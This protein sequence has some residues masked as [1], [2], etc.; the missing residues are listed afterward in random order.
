MQCPVCHNE[1]GPQDAFCNHC[2]ASVTAAP[3]TA[4]VPPQTPFSPP[5]TSAAVPPVST[6]PP[7]SA[8]PPQVPASS[9]LSP[10]AA[11]AIAYLTFVPAVIFLLMEPYNRIP[12]VRFHSFQSIGLT[13]VWFVLH[14]AS[15]LLLS[16]FGFLMH[17]FLGGIISLGLFIA[18]LIS[19]IKA[20]QGEWFKLPIIGD[21][22]LKQVQS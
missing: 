4:P 8:I 2:G 16:P 21:F 10:N 18:W 6:V 3:G 11:S 15:T 20:S 5:P 9:G 1:V 19:I 7:V 17:A 14:V 22:A 12:L 13:V